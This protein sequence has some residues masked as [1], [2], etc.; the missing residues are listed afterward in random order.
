MEHDREAALSPTLY[1]MPAPLSRGSRRQSVILL[2]V[3]ILMTAGVFAGSLLPMQYKAVL[4]THGRLHS[5]I[6]LFV[7]GALAFVAARSTRSAPLRL[8]FF[9]A[10]LAFGF[11]VEVTEHITYHGALEW[12]DVLVDAIGISVATLLALL[13]DR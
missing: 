8:A 13:L 11:A 1:A 5:W 10:A 4:H 3:A 6:H 12:R 7:F 9:A 2:F